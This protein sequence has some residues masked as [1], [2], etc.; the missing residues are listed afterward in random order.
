MQAQMVRT[1][2][3]VIVVNQSLSFYELAAVHLDQQPPNLAEAQVAIDAFA[4]VIEALGP[5]LGPNEAPLREAL[6]QIRLAFV[7]VKS[8]I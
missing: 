3:A 2:A 6:A 4:A 1:S 5:R 7:E 8:G